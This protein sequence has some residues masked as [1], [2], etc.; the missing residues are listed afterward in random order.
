MHTNPPAKSR[1]LPSQDK[2]PA[3]LRMVRSSRYPTATDMLHCIRASVRQIQRETGN[4]HHDTTL[5][6][7]RRLGWLLGQAMVTRS[8]FDI[9]IVLGSGAELMMFPD[10]PTLDQCAAA[11]DAAGQRALRSV[12]WAVR[13]RCSKAGHRVRRFT[14][15]PWLEAGRGSAAR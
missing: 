4:S 12:V 15:D 1:Q 5:E 11:V 10:A 13:H 14:I 3:P 2:P 8:P 6:I 9:A 7:E